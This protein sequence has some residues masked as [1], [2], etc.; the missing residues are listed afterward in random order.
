MLFVERID[1]PERVQHELD[2]YNELMPGARELSATLFVEITEPGRIRA[3]LDRLIGIDE[4]V[5][6]VLGA[7]ADQRALRA[8][9]DAK[10]LEEDRISAVQY[11]RF[12][13]DARRCRRVRRAGALCGDPD[14]PP[15]LRARGSAAARRAR[16]PR[17]RPARRPALARAAAARRVAEGARGA[18]LGRRR[19]RAAAG[20]AAAP[21]SPRGGIEHRAHVG[22]RDRSRTLE[23]ALRGG[24]P[25]RLR[26]RASATAAAASSPT[27][28]PAR[29][30]A[31]TSCRARARAEI[32][33]PHQVVRQTNWIQIQS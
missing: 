2:V 31:G 5:A 16:E 20:R 3:E 19:A 10:Q 23:R 4:H 24:A 6:L 29:R 17:R 30:C 11:I 21:G 27:S 12:A 18:L 14:L 8:R 13:L 7:G 25:H 26:R 1:E 22:G 15:E 33:T 32:R 9:F 28:R